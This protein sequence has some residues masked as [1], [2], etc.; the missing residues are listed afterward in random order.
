[1]EYT[2]EENKAI[3]NLNE[4][5]THKNDVDIAYGYNIERPYPIGREKIAQLEIIKNLLEKQ[6]NEINKLNNKNKRIK[7]FSNNLF[8]D[9]YISKESIRE[10]IDDLQRYKGLVM[11]EKYNYDAII[12]HLKE[13]LGE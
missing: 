2:E 6:Q 4:I 13:L 3:E 9:D 5:L 1:M 12:R 7:Y 10:K 8:I 11:Y